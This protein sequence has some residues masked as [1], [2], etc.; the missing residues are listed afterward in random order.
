MTTNLKE[1]LNQAI[2]IYRQKTAVFQNLQ[3]ELLQMEGSIKTL[4]EL[5]ASEEQTDEEKE[6]EKK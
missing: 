2:S 5:I 3:N 1:K 4:Q 6:A